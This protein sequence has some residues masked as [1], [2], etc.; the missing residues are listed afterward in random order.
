MSTAEAPLDEREEIEMLLPWFVTGKLGEDD[1]ARVSAWLE[2]EPDMRRQL[3]I[4]R[5]EQ[6]QDVRA[7]EILAAPRQLSVEL[8]IAAA[9]LGSDRKAGL[10]QRIGAALLDIFTAPTPGA[11][12]WAAA[13][14]VVVI[15][16]Q[17][18][19]IGT[20]TSRDGAQY[21]TASGGSHQP[22]DG[23][24]ALVRFADG[25]TMADVTAGLAARG[26][27][28]VEGPKPG[29]LFRI[30]IAETRL[31]EGA[32][33]LRLTALRSLDRLVVLVMPSN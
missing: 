1:L 11:V 15:V 20:M 14:A 9:G 19:F 28:I 31:D 16:A 24:F 25:A 6:E 32:R 22:A 7:N 27:S 8:T 18:A 29:G 33:E 3:D 21:E 26:M 13:V 5:D 17:G 23:T 10:A 30:R 4:I 2:R 12:R